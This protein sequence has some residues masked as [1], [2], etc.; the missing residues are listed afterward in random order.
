MGVAEGE[1]FRLTSRRDERYH[2]DILVRK[3]DIYRGERSVDFEA[4]YLD[5]RKVNFSL[6]SGNGIE[7]PTIDGR[8]EVSVRNVH[9]GRRGDMIANLDFYTDKNYWWQKIRDFD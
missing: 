8:V 1:G 3:I 5:G 4:K 9:P 2:I 7:L 6:D